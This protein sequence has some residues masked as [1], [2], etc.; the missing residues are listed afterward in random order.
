MKLGRKLLV[1]GSVAAA[2]L[3]TAIIP[4]ASSNAAVACVAAWSSTDR[5]SV[6]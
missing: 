5:K 1:V 3:A 6:V 2:G 4:M